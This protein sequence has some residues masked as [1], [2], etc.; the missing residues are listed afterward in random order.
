[1]EREKETTIDAFECRYKIWARE[2]AR[3]KSE[4]Q[5][6]KAKI[7]L[8]QDKDLTD[9][10]KKTDAQG[11]QIAMQKGK[12]DRQTTLN[13]GLE[14]RLVRSQRD[15]EALVHSVGLGEIGPDLHV[16]SRSF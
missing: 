2:E 7:R 4:L 15:L 8:N 12:L 10:R 16:P 1:L 9:S 11:N 3:L 6:I 14:E 5:N 13:T